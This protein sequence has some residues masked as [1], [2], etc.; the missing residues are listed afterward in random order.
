MYAPNLD[1]IHRARSVHSNVDPLS[2]LL[3]MPPAHTS[4]ETEDKPSITAHGDLA[5]EQERQLAGD[6]TIASTFVAWTLDECLETIGSTWTAARNGPVAEHAAAFNLTHSED[7][8]LDTLQT[9][10]EYWGAVNPP[11]NVHV[12]MNPDFRKQW[13][14]AYQEDPVLKKVW[15]DPLSA[16]ENWQ[17]S[18]RFFKSN[19]GLLF[20]RDE[21]FQPRLCIPMSMRNLVLSEVHNNALETAH[22]GP[23]KLWQNLSQRFYWKRM[24]KD[25]VTYC[26]SGHVSLGN[27]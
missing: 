13:I 18:R 1:I 5:A 9:T 15:N 3:R 20:F 14:K 22:A 19:E 6:P 25:I 27:P 26:Q 4:P 7:E 12:H 8:A 21:D 24:R 16:T 10:E 17:Q 23:E 11:P 2:R